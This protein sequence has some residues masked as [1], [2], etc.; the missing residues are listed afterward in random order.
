MYY[1]IIVPTY[2][3]GKYIEQCLNSILQQNI[4]RSEY[5][6]IVSDASS[7][8]DT[9][10]LAQRSADI[11]VIT[12]ERGISIGRNRGAQKAKGDI[13]VFFDADTIL[14]PDFLYECK[15]TF[16]NPS[17]V[18]MTGK[19]I[20]NDGGILQCLVYRCTYFL[21]SLFNLFGLS[22][23]PGICV[24]YRRNVFIEAGGFREDFGVVED[25]DLSRRIS[26]QG[27]CAVNKKAFVFVSTRRL[28][29]YLISTILFH[30]YCDIRYL[31]T[32]KAPAVYSK[33]EEMHSWRDIW[34]QLSDNN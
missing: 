13:L 28:N 8:D 7:I 29:K 21:V 30:V 1:S 3:E 14:T 4:D 15:K 20:P 25:L 17:V 2:N 6:I 23:F 27:N 31:I 22:L 33:S 19:A 5:E 9:Y 10:T 34:K 12:K 11:I 32:G 26:R 16:S 24:A 18:G